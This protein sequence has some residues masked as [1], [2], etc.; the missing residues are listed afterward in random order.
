MTKLLENSLEHVRK[1][2]VVMDGIETKL[3]DAQ[4]RLA[5]TKLEDLTLREDEPEKLEAEYRRWGYRLAE[6]VGAPVYVYSARYRASGSSSVTSV[7]VRS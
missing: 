7:P 1:L 4:D 3:I 2:L 6:L 5:A